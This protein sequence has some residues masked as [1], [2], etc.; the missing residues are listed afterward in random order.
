VR[1]GQHIRVD[2]FTRRRPAGIKAGH[3]ACCAAQIGDMLMR[4]SRGSGD[5]MVSVMGIIPRRGRAAPGDAEHQYQRNPAHQRPHRR[6][7]PIPRPLYLKQPYVQNKTLV[8]LKALVV[9]AIQRLRLGKETRSLGLTLYRCAFDLLGYSGQC[10]TGGG[11]VAAITV[12]VV[13]TT[14]TWSNGTND[15]NLERT[16]AGRPVRREP[17]CREA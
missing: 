13:V 12:A 11:E 15:L 9:P 7:T 10:Q 14:V 8:T 6:I 17:Y 4:R 16:F 2:A 5:L 3:A 1:G